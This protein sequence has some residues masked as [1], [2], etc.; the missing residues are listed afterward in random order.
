MT[1][2]APDPVAAL[3]GFARALRAAGVA[4]D[5][6]RLTTSVEALAHVDPTDRDGVYWSARLSLCSE[7]ADLPVFDA[8]FQTWFGLDRPP[9]PMPGPAR[10]P[11]A[12][13]GSLRPL[14]AEVDGGAAADDEPLRTA[15]GTAEALRH[16]DVTT[17]TP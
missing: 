7:P 2:A 15:A 6:T 11:A 8:L 14:A 17:L 4:A 13:P 9:L 16:R 5:R 1:G 3:T 10:P 12:Q